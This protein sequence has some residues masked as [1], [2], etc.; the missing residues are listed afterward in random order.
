VRA[1]DLRPP[2][3][4]AIA[5]TVLTISPVASAEAGDFIWPA[6]RRSQLTVQGTRG[7]EVTIQRVAG[8]VE[9]Y[10]SSGQA[11]AI[12]VVRS[13]DA[14]GNGIEAAFPGR[15]RISVRFHPSGPVKREPAFC[16]DRAPVRQNGV[17]S[18]VIRFAGER[19]FTR[20]AVE[21]GRGFVYH[22]FK[23]V[24]KDGDDGDSRSPPFYFLQ[25][26]AR[27]GGRETSFTATKP[28]DETAFGESASYFASQNERRHGM[29]IARI[30]VA[31]AASETFAIAGLPNRPE[32]ATI[33][34]PHPF[35]GTASFHASPG[36]RAEWEGTLA[37]DLPG[38][39]TV[40]LTGPLFRP[41][42]CRG[43]RCVP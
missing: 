16:G 21:N 6:E 26:S 22:S 35:S 9:L 39:G 42:L 7:F 1:T 34:P 17:F 11:A 33:A 8:H 29:L 43:R 3:A 41:E 24:C 23:E 13:E 36:G 20:V 40:K 32:S 19:E 27:S 12:Y 18:G 37:V 10:A 30:A 5:A 38:A 15:G 28:I 2:L 14:P 25:E 31:N 4:V